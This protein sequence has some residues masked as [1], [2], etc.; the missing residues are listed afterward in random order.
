M[1]TSLFGMSRIGNVKVMSN[2][3]RP[4]KVQPHG[5]AVVDWN[6]FDKMREEFPICIDHDKDMI[7]FKMLTKPAKEGGDLR[8]AQFTD[9]IATAL[10]MLNYLN[11]KFPCKENS[12]T[13]ANLESALDWQEVRTQDRQH[14]KVE[15][16]N[17]I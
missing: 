2:K 6:E 7:S 15:G 10:K 5:G 3:E 12:H 4:M 11:D 14:R 16:K 17:L 13:I 9:L 8:N 1:I